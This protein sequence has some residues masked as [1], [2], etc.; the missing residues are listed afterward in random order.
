MKKLLYTSIILAIILSI[1]SCEKMIEIDLPTDQINTENV[2]KDK[3]SANAALTNLY[4]NL[5]ESS[6]YT[7]NSQ[8]IGTSLALYT[9][10]L[11]SLST[12][13][14]ADSFVLFNNLLDPTKNIL[15][16]IWNTSYTHIYA[17][18][19]FI[20]GVVKSE[21]IS[22]EEKLQLLG[23]GYI[24]RAMYYQALT[25]LFGDIP[26]TTSTDYKT[27]T[28]I[29]KTSSFEVLNYIEKDLLQANE[30]LSYTYRSIDRYYP[31][32]AVA[33]LILAKNYLLQKNYEK[34]EFYATLVKDNSMYNLET[35]LNKVFKNTAKSTLW[36]LSNS[37]NTAATYE[38]RNYVMIT[39]NWTSRL[40]NSLLNSFDNNDLRKIEWVKL[41]PNTTNNFAFKYKNHLTNT[42]ECSILFRLEEAYF[43]LSESL[44][45]QN[46]QDKATFYLN[47]IRQRAGLSPLLNTLNKDQ[48][49]L[50][51]LEESKKE[52]F[53]EHG[54]R[55][56]DLKRN[57]KL[58]LLKSTKIN[59]QDKHALF[60]YPEKE[61]LINPNLNPQNEY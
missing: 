7:G 34:A 8:G 58:S 48:V 13:P 61:L 38:A 27:N 56:F 17:I 44:I 24:L 1:T 10:E 23:E 47:T 20:N 46:K 40:T 19:S 32:K 36:Q 11:E 57:N 45:Y 50:A 51:M 60:P 26:Y 52:F 43:I 41:Y 25:Q 30:N 2:F 15:S 21:T 4:I 55:F 31:N 6:I 29:K 42:D 22:K 33:E 53:L 5:R 49:L 54:R 35:D 18:N 39:S 12:S 14:T 9:D 3:R 16:N 37:N 59:W 28:T